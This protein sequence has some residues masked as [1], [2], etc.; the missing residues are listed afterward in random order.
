MW[1]IYTG[2][3]LAAKSLCGTWGVIYACERV[4]WTSAWKQ[5]VTSCSRRD[6]HL[7]GPLTAADITYGSKR[8]VWWRCAKGHEWQASAGSRTIKD[9]AA[10]SAPANGCVPA[11]MTLPVSSQSLPFSGTGRRTA[12]CVRAGNAELKPQSLVALLAGSRVAGRGGCAH[13]ER[14]R[15]SLLR[16]E[17]SAD[18]LQRPRDP[19]TAAVKTVAPETE[20]KPDARNGHPRL[21]PQGLVAMPGWPRMEGRH[22]LPLRPSKKRLPHLRGAGQQAVAGKTGL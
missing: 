19:Q 5:D 20:R 14:Q 1:I 12:P 8:K 17:E 22:L 16:G 15:M 10:P 9:T 4:Y 2:P 18:R 11:K 7:N 13:V 3:K 21:P 6:E